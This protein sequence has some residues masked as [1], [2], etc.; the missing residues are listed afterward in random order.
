M[1][2]WNKFKERGFVVKETGPVYYTE[3]MDATIAWF[4]KTLGWY[5]EIDERNEDGQGTYGCAFDLPREFESLHIAP[6]TGLHF[7]YGE[8]K[9]GTVA[10]MK[11]QGIEKLHA[12]V[13]NSGWEK[14]NLNDTADFETKL[15]Q[16]E[17]ID[18]YI[19]QFFE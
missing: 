5:C 14:V 1:N 3:D 17:T 11:V 2:D 10:F 4:T 8:P 13:I 18:G 16:I 12:H 6:F 9:G 15:C 19:L 7:L